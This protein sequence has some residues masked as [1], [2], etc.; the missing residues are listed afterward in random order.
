MDV[1]IVIVVATTPTP[2]APTATNTDRKVFWFSTQKQYKTVCGCELFRRMGYIF[3]FSD[4]H[5]NGEIFRP[6]IFITFFTILSKLS[7]IK[8]RWNDKDCVNIFVV[9]NFSNKRWPLNHW[10]VK[11]KRCNNKHLWHTSTL[12]NICYP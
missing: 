11:E 6:F 12:Q 8:Q 3:M 7:N 1:A 9:W 2:M 4:L 5:K 10:A